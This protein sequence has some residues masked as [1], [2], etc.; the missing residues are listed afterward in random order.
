MQKHIAWRSKPRMTKMMKFFSIPQSAT[1]CPIS[2]SSQKLILGD[3]EVKFSRL[4]LPRDQSQIWA[5]SRWIFEHTRKID[6]TICNQIM[7]ENL[8]KYWLWF[9]VR[10]FLQRMDVIGEI[11]CQILFLHDDQNVLRVHFK[12]KKI[13]SQ[14][15]LKKIDRC[16][17]RKPI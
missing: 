7:R 15:Q 1:L 10:A 4:N 16:R 11:S 5:L 17:Q 13:I 12:K 3:Y 9:L 8:H 2:F 14:E 6:A